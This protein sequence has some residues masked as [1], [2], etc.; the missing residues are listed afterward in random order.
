MMENLI[1]SHYPIENSKKIQQLNNFW[2]I[3][4]YNCIKDIM[5]TETNQSS[6][7]PLNAFALNFGPEIGFYFS[8]LV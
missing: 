6:L 3:E 1:I 2:K 5:N 4:Q 7:R 8:F